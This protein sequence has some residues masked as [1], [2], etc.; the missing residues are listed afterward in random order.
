[1]N[2][3]TEDSREP[4]FISAS[5]ISKYVFCN[6]SW[7]LDRAGAPKN[8]G[9]GVRIQKGITS[10]STLKKRR[11]AVRIATWS[12]IALIL[13]IVSYLFILLS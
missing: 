9:A 3:R 10:H 13:V 7:Y 2:G 4:R 12:I 8:R 11:N 1:M 6:V 5:E